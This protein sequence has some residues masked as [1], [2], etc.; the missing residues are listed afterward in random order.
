MKTYK[1]EH[2]FFLDAHNLITQMQILRK[3]ERKRAKEREIRN[4]KVDKATENPAKIVH[5][6]VKDDKF[7]DLYKKIKKNKIFLISS[8]IFMSVLIN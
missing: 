7:F 1:F 3:V 4:R 5:L 6:V 2:Y 8:F